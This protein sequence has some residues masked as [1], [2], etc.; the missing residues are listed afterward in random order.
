MFL[1]FCVLGFGVFLVHPET[2]L[3]DWLETSV[4]RAYCQIWHISRFFW[5]FA[6]WIIFFPYFKKIGFLGI[7]G[8]PYC[9]IGATIRIG[10]EML[11]LPCA[12]FFL[13][14]LECSYRGLKKFSTSFSL[15]SK[16]LLKLL[17]YKRL[18]IPVYG[19]FNA[20]DIFST[21]YQHLGISSNHKPFCESWKQKESS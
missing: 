15:F 2:T 6:F 13:T 4:Q 19:I 10:R 16:V 7:F 17:K 9:G 8:P 3:P 5:V 21:A 11:C 1:I 18:Y 12:G 14:A 20:W